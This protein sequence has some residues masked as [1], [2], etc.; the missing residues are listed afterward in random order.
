MT[1]TRI[2]EKAKFQNPPLVELLLDISVNLRPLYVTPSASNKRLTKSQ[3]NKGQR[4]EESY[5]QALEIHK[6]DLDF[7]NS[8]ENSNWME[9][10]FQKALEKTTDEWGRTDYVLNKKALPVID[11]LDNSWI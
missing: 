1:S 7:L 3:I 8:K 11:V 6:E 5:Q 10:A 4:V 9:D 2:I